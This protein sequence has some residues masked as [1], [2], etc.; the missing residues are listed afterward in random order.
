[1]EK[2]PCVVVGGGVIGLSIAK[3]LVEKGIYTLVLEKGPLIGCE[4][5]SRNSEVLHAGI[6]YP[7]SSLKAEACV[8]GKD[9]L[10]AYIKSRSVPFQ[11]CGKLIVSQPDLPEDEESLRRLFDNALRCGLKK[12]VDISWL[13]AAEAKIMEPNVR[14]GAAILSHRTG[15]LS[16]HHLLEQLALDCERGGGGDIVLGCTATGV[17]RVFETCCSSSYVATGGPIFEVETTHGPIRTDRLIDAA[18]LNASFLMAHIPSF[19]RAHIPSAVYFAKGNYF[20]LTG[21]AWK[22]K[23]RDTSLTTTTTNN[24]SPSS[25]SAVYAP[26]SR[27]IYP[28]PSPGG[29]GIHATLDLEGRVRFGPNVEW[30]LALPQPP[31]MMTAGKSDSTAS[32]LN[33]NCS[34]NNS[35]MRYYSHRTDREFVP[36][37]NVEDPEGTMREL[38][39]LAVRQYWPAVRAEDLQADYAGIRP[40]LTGP[41]SLSSS[42][43]PSPLPVLVGKGVRG[44]KDEKKD[45]V[46]E[47]VEHMGGMA[48]TGDFVISGPE[49]HGVP[50]LVCLLGIESPGLTSC[51]H[52]GDM[53]VRKLLLR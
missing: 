51:L 18:G 20:K 13:T 9:Q 21:S 23:D 14:T 35:N 44:M 6:Y 19:P 32:S 40:K 1:M 30:V 33:G 26:F 12:D 22:N 31:I 16:T 3:K 47:E 52:I 8:Q 39:A 10:R 45:E 36:N 4:N 27:L 53:A 46:D 48:P 24:I 42:S 28:T 5:S 38:F 29:L 49:T 7:P 41:V 2:V 34:N 37:F 50:N 11:E 43:S 25:F 15:I 17:K